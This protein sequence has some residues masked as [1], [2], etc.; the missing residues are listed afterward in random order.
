MSRHRVVIALGLSQTLAWGSSF[1]LPALLI[2]PMAQGVGLSEPTVWAVFSGSLA[3]SAVTGPRAGA[4]IDRWGGRQVLMGTNLIFALGLALL[5]LAQGPLGLC[6]AWLLLGIGMGAGLYDAA[7]ATLARLY[8]SEARS[9][10]TGITLIAG[11]ASTVGWPL[12]AALEHSLGWRGACWAWAALHLLIGLPLNA[13]LPRAR[14]AHDV[15]VVPRAAGS[16]SA[17]NTSEPTAPASPLTVALLAWVFAVVAFTSTALAAHLPGLLALQGVSAAGV[18]LAGSLIGPAQVA[19]RLLEFG[20]LRRLHPLVSGRVAACMHPLAA[21]LLML[22]GAPAAAG[23]ALLHGAGNGVLTITRGTLPLALFGAAGY[24]QRQ[25]WL[26]LPGRLTAALAP[27][28]FGVLLA[29]LGT[30]VLWVSAGLG[31]SAVLALMA[32]QPR[33]SEGS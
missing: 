10:I 22:L 23:F 21:T 16:P 19:A 8:G 24:G 27:W 15:D 28:S 29:G 2:G 30:Q 14:P 6:A 26:M 32:I 31:L 25:G 9:A 13:S 12:T 17:A 33:T 3:I 18:V 20:V 11:F 4:R 7:F 5:A 1:Y